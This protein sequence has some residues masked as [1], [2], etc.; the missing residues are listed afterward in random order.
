M[1]SSSFLA[2]VVVGLVA[3]TIASVISD[4]NRVNVGAVIA[5]TAV[6][7]PVLVVGAG[8]LGLWAL[9]AGATR[10]SAAREPHLV[11]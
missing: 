8:Q 7:W 9:I 4:R 3:A 1:F 5:L 10:R 6:T 2:Y 11:R